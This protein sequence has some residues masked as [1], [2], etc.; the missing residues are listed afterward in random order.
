MRKPR[1]RWRK[2]ARAWK[3]RGHLSLRPWSGDSGALLVCGF[4]LE[5]LGRTPRFSEEGGSTVPSW[6][7]GGPVR[8]RP[9]EFYRAGAAAAA[10]TA[11]AAGAATTWACAPPRW[12][13][14]GH[15]PR[16]TSTR[17]RGRR[18]EAVRRAHAVVPSARGR[19]SLGVAE[20]ASYRRGAVADTGRRASRFSVRSRLVYRICACCDKTFHLSAYI[21]LRYRK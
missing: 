14:G 9:R 10:E 3:R 16:R 8:W 18:A 6:K 7:R 21:A 13:A 17:S 15:R 19:G 2:R 11:A 5:P 12:P 1:S 20:A 4:V